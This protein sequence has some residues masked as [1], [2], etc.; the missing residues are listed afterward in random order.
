MADLST[1][2]EHLITK[3]ELLEGEI[4]KL[5]ES[6]NESKKLI[7]IDATKAPIKLYLVGKY[8]SFDKETGELTILVEGTINYYPLE[9][10][11]SK[12]LPFPDSRVLIFNIEGETNRPFI[13]AFDGGRLVEPS[14]KYVA[15]LSSVDYMHNL[16]L[17]NTLEYGNIRLT[18]SVNFLENMKIKSGKQLSIKKIQVATEVYFVPDI[19][20]KTVSLDSKKIYEFLSKLM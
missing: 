7:D 12:R 2:N 18:P 5:Q 4:K 8:K 6:L 1:E 16:V 15:T 17:V 19:N 13:L 10:Y 11:G 9:S 20:E 3:V 14:Q